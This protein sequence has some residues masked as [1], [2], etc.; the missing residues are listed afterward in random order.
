MQ[1]LVYNFIASFANRTAFIMGKPPVDAIINSAM[2]LIKWSNHN[3]RLVSLGKAYGS[4]LWLS[5][6]DLTFVYRSSTSTIDC[7]VVMGPHYSHLFHF[8]VRRNPLMNLV[9]IRLLFK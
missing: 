5:E 4:T 6:V 3:L 7:N 2:L 8:L 1:N 9:K